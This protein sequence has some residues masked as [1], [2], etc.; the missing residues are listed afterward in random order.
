MRV[1]G[2]VDGFNL[3]KGALEGTGH[4]WLD[5][6]ALC[7]RLAGSRVDRV[8]YCTAPL[9]ALPGDPD[10]VVRQQMYL[11]ALSGNPRI[12]IF[13][14]KFRETRPRMHRV[15]DERCRCCS[16]QIAPRC[17]CCTGRTIQV[18]KFEEKGSDVQLAVQLV[19]DAYRDLFDLALVISNDSD[20]QPAIH[21]VLRVDGKQ[22]KV[23]SPRKGGRALSGTSRGY[24]SNGLLRSSQ[25]PNVVVDGVGRPVTKPAP[26]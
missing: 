17:G 21:A 8:A 12:D 26:W 23:V 19:A 3:Y 14:G 24:L 4:K 22:V 6:A 9:V 7:D 16:G 20:L 5:L 18:V 10:V 1:R 25:M 11:R 15:A 2:Y 13:K